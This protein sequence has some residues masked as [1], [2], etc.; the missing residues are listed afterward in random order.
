MSEKYRSEAVG[1]GKYRVPESTPRKHGGAVRLL[2]LLLVLI[3]LAGGAVGIYLLSSEKPFAA[4]GDTGSANV[5]ALQHWLAQL[6]Y[7]D[8]SVT[9]DFDDATYDAYWGYCTAHGLTASRSRDGGLI[10]SQE[11]FE[12]MTVCTAV[13]TA[14]PSPTPTATPSPTPTAT[15][16]AT[17]S[18][19]PTA[20]AAPE[21]KALC[22]M[23]GDYQV[24]TYSDNTCVIHKYKGTAQTLTIPTRIDDCLVTSIDE[25][26][27][28]GCDSL[29]TVIIP[30][31]VHSI[32]RWAF[33]FCDALATVTIPESVTF[34][35]STA[36]NNCPSLTLRVP[37][38]SCAEQYAIGNGIPY[39]TY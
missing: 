14:S 24:S 23:A 35:E 36:F 39:T 20:A 2:I 22:I 28:K 16:T 15:P 6:G 27:F 38:G 29:F 11:E 19:T 26:A 3:L 12:A 17:P 25:Y 4:Y 21:P 13:P 5:R 34:I 37:A 1:S 7:Y 9:G 8:G 10:V 30:G 32:G 31:Y 33:A 18:P